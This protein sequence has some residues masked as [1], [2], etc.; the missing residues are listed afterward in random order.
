MGL[1]LLVHFARPLLRI[2]LVTGFVLVSLGALLK[3]SLD[4]VL[5][6]SRPTVTRYVRLTRI[7]QLLIPTTVLAGTFLLP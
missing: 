1:V 4:V 5:C 3:P 2:A 7:G 6:P